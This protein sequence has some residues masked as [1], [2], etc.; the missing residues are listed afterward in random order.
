MVISYRPAQTFSTTE[1][2]NTP[3]CVLVISFG[4]RYFNFNQTVKF[5]TESF[6]RRF[7]VVGKAMRIQ[8]FSSQ[9]M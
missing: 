7:I 1:A 2:I 4:E 3:P 5:V 9:V 6:L 8:T